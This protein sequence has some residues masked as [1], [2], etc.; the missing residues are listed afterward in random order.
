VLRGGSWMNDPSYL[1]TASRDHYDAS[2]RYL[3]H[4]FRVARPPQ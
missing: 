4:G 2:V 1:R 3:T